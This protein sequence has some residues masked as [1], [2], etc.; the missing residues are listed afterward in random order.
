[1]F[2]ILRE[3]PKND[4][5]VQVA[6]MLAML[7]DEHKAD[8]VFIDF[9]YGTGIYSAGLAMGRVGWQMV[10]FGA[11]APNPGF[12]N[13]RA[14]IW[15]Q[16]KQWLKNG[17]AIPPDHGLYTE[18]C[19]PETISRLD[20]RIQLESKQDMKDRGLPSP[21]KA[22]ALAISFAFP[23]SKTNTLRASPTVAVQASTANYDPLRRR[24]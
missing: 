21:N 10:Q 5:D 22:D 1:M 6:T 16:M 3:I 24:R 4:N 9:G 19:G 14:W 13:M 20:G 8:A 2:K 15:D 11:A 7:Q 23:V 18:L 12:M 17:G